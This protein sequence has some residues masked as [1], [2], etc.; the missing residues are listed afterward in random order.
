MFRHQG[1]SRTLKHNLRIATILSFVAGIVNV[2]GF[3]AFKQLTTN[4]TGHFALFI[5]DVANFDFWK[6]TIYFLYIFS[7]LLGSFLS[8]FLIEKYSENKKLNVFVLPTVIECLVL[9]SIG[10]ISNF[11]ELEYANLIICLLLFAMGLQNSFVTKISNAV[12]RTTHL[13]GLFTD[14]GIDLSLLCFPKLAPQKELLK[15]NIKLRVYIILFFFAGGLI[16]GFFYSKL[17]LKLNTLI[18][19]ALFLLASLFFDD[20]RYKVIKTRRKY[21]QKKKVQ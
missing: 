18:L 9:I 20:F 8:S 14:L 7:F 4:V 17:D 21:Y 6:G 5:Y 1:K 13:T 16:G 12:V 2:S 10:L 11:M 3:L 19:A 15:S